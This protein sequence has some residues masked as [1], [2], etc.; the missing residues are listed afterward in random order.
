MLGCRF[1][2]VPR[3][4]NVVGKHSPPGGEVAR[5]RCKVEN[6]ISPCEKV[7]PPRD[8]GSEPAP[9]TIGGTTPSKVGDNRL[10]PR[11]ETAV[12]KAELMRT[13]QFFY[14]LSADSASCTSNDHAHG[15]AIP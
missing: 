4:L 2:D 5:I 3:C 15:Y 11:Y 10:S 6:N 14:H 1:E 8:L 9:P 13:E 12:E 7:R